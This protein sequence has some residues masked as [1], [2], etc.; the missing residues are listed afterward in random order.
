M[1]MPLRGK[2]SI[3]NDQSLKKDNNNNNLRA[4]A[5]PEQIVYEGSRVHLEGISYPSNQKL[6]WTQVSGPKAWNMAIKKIPVKIH[7]ILLLLHL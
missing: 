3:V 6:V 2:S 7:R 1:P 4:Y 5:G